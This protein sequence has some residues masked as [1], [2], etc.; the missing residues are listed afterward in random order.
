MADVEQPIT[1]GRNGITIGG[2][3]VPG[4]LA[5]EVTVQEDREIP[6]LWHVTVTFLTST[7]PIS[8]SSTVDQPIN[9][10]VIRPA[11]PGDD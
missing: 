8:D 1:I 5:N 11:T 2:I 3:V 6:D 9:T 4:V 7:Y 10:R